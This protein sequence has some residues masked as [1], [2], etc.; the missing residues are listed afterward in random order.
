VLLNE[1][2]WEKLLMAAYLNPNL[3]LTSLPSY[4][5]DIWA[6]DKTGEIFATDSG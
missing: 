4:D 1:G 3:D 2:L 6:L 5:R